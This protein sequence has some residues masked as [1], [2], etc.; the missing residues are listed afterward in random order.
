MTMQNKVRNLLPIDGEM[1]FY[2]NYFCTNES[3]MY[4]KYLLTDIAWQQEQIKLFGK[5]LMQPRLSAWHGDKGK[6]YT[7]SGI[8]LEP[9]RWTNELLQIKYKIEKLNS[10][11]FNSALL[12]LYRNGEDSMGWHRDNEKELGQQPII[13]S[14]N[15]GASRKFCL[16][17]IKIKDLK[18][19]LNLTDGSYLHMQGDT[20]KYWKHCIPKENNCSNPRINLTFRIIY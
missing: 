8:T 15:F 2:P 20:Q 14:V 4:F 10:I 6:L 9:E 17:H 12:N 16:Q 19:T 13:G 5:W 7:Y 3:A 11:E 18:I 1:Y